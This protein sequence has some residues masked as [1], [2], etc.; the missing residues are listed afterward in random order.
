[1]ARTIAKLLS[2]LIVTGV[3]IIFLGY[4]HPWSALFPSQ[5]P[6][7]I[8]RLLEALGDSAL[9][10][11]DRPIAAILLYGDEVIGRGFTTVHRD[12]NAGGHAEINALS[13]ALWRFGNRRFMDLNRDSLVLVT[14][15]EPCPMCR[16]AIVEYGITR[17]E[18]LAAQP[19][20]DLVREDLRIVRYYLTRH[21]S[22][23][24]SL[25]DSLF[26]R[27]G[28]GRMSNTYAPIQATGG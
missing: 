7:T 8:V 28:G 6:R 13:S 12:E 11:G 27:E 15:Y 21:I 2:A 26:R 17:V 9:R 5:Q 24:E 25:Q 14:T 19:P 4:Y 1:M 10:A 3:V 23:P 16:G 20:P 22:G 18:I